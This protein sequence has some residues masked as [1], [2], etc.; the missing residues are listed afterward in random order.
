MMT[1]TLV[2]AALTEAGLALSD[3]SSSVTQQA[4][5]ALLV[6]LGVGAQPILA[7][8][9]SGLLLVL[10]RPFRVGDNVQI[11]DD[12]F[13]VQA[14]TAFFVT[15]TKFDN[16]HVSLPNS[17]V[18]ASGKPLTNF[19][20]N[21]IVLLELSVHVHAGQQPCASVRAA[22]DAA[23][24]AFH[25]KLEGML[26]ASGVPDAPAAAAA[27]PPPT[28]IGPCAFT[29]QGVQWML[30]PSVPERAWMRAVDLGN[31]CIHDALMEAGVPISEASDRRAITND[32]GV[33]GGVQPRV[34]KI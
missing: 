8:F 18:L 29:E 20:A 26:V 4:M 23:A 27:L 7:N 30:K 32:V 15:G 19:S 5:T 25:D 2:N 1:C 16:M 3:G 13:H 14:I 10:F 21:K 33:A 11:G 12:W 31:E 9:T 6:A 17:A 34:V 28:V 24:A 22:M